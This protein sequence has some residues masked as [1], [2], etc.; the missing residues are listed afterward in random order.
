MKEREREKTLDRNYA[1]RTIAKYVLKVARLKENEISNWIKI[2]KDRIGKEISED[3]NRKK[4]SNTNRF[5]DKN[6]FN[7]SMA[8][9]FV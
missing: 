7:Y 4:R 8:F 1:H 2:V 5:K 6:I 3:V 9:G